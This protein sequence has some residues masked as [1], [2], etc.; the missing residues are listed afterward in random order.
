MS[1]IP[2][3]PDAARTA[4]LIADRALAAVFQPIVD[5]GSGTVIAY[6]GLIRGPRGTDLETPAA[7]FAQAAREGATIAL[8]HA[9][10]ITCLDAFAALGCDGKLFL[11][12]SAG[13]ILA[14]ARER[15]HA[16]TLLERAQIAAERI[17]IE[18]TEQN[19]STDLAQV[20]P[21]V[22][23]L[24][25]AG[26]QFAL[27][28][29][30]TANASMNLWLRLHPD[31]VKIDRF[32]IHDIALD[33]LKF[34]AVRAMQHFAHASGAKLIAEGI[35]HERDLIVVRDMGICCVQGFLL[36]RPHAQ[37]ERVVA[38]AARDAIRAPHIA[39]FP[40]ASRAARPSGT[41]AAKMLV[42]APALP[43]D[44]TSNDVLALFN[45]MPELHA[46]ALVEHE[47]PVALV[48]RRSFMDRFALPYHRE[49][50]GRKPCLQFAN[51]APLMIENATTVEQLAL[52]LANND[53]RY[54]ADG[55]VITEHGRYVGLGTGESLVRAVTEMRIEAA[56][57]AN[58]LT[59]LP[60]NI[61]ISAHIDRLLARD[62]GFHACYVDLNQFK[63]FNDQYGYWQG[64]EVLKYAATVLA[65][66]CDP[67][68]DFLGHVGGDDFLVLFQSDD[69]HARAA[70][71]IGRFNDGA[72]R[73][74]TLVDQ[75]AGG[76]H[77]ED[78]HGNPA[79]F[80]FVT[81]AIGAVGVPAGAH[82]AMRYG[83]DEI[84]SVAALAKRRA[85]QQPDGLAVVD[86]D[87]G[88][89]ALLARGEP[90]ATPH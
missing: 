34:E 57:Y 16:Y 45:R 35:E 30:G 64:D 52:L 18:L 69:W 73:F 15:E 75:R 39:V 31:V 56:R 51:D 33:P 85:K 27:D 9:A 13:A 43:R 1:A 5:L 48:N 38:P 32:F 23:S 68:R 66:I 7:L 80:G 47:R 88:R 42:A 76:L 83:S 50:F 36:G 49:V 62:A 74:Y 22:A 84:A 86:L 53:Q 41:V 81:M 8:E 44:V 6:E 90:P 72:Q 19:A 12:F 26:I 82:R 65:G 67:Q 60:G 54:L 71:A 21:A 61:P 28:D 24:R 29:Y 10:A 2:A 58:P 78:R 55:F 4:R 11:N 3:A 37:P 25:D 87:A 63:P 70:A 77:G 17:V 20:A 14:L 46:V 89:A 59:F 79:F 40:D